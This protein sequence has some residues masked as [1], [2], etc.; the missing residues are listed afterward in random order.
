MDFASRP[1]NDFSCPVICAVDAS[2][3]LNSM[4]AARKLEELNQD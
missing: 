3:L 4:A 2:S 1:Q